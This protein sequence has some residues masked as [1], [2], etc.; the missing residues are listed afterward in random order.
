MWG[1]SGFFLNNWFHLDAE[2]KDKPKF[3]SI[4]I[5]GSNIRPSLTPTDARQVFNLLRNHFD[6]I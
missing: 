5:K 4:K 1:I 6:E 2:R 3:L